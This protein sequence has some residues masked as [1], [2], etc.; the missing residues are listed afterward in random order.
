MILKTSNKKIEVKLLTTLPER[1]KSFR[2]K[3]DVITS[4]ICFYKKRNI[5]TYFF[6]QKVDIIFTDR[7]NRVLKISRNAS[8]ERFI[9]GRRGVFFIYILNGNDAKDI[10]VN[11]ILNIRY[12]DSD[13]EVLARYQKK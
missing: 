12:S 11:D 4:G 8:S 3:L 13:E 7:N 6:C 2:F 9:R 5:N 1:V 10:H